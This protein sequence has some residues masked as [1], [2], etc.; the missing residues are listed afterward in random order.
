V[1]GHRYNP[2]LASP[3]I[4]D[5]T[6]GQFFYNSFQVSVSKRYGHKLSW[7][8][9]YTFA[10]SV[11]DASVDFNVESV[12]DPATSQNIFDPKGSRGRQILTFGTIS[13]RMSFTTC[14]D[15]GASWVAGRFRVLQ[16]FTAASHLPQCS[17]STM[18]ICNRWLFRNVRT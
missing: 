11:D 17:T 4:T 7:L 16:A 6:D 2:N 13:W 14:L 10:H 15:E 8:V 1:L 3:V 9:S 12:N 18:P 5:L